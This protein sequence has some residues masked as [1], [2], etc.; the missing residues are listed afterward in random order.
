M[1]KRILHL[2]VRVDRSLEDAIQRETARE[3]KV[4]EADLPGYEIKS[5]EPVGM[6]QIHSD[7]IYY[8]TVEVD[9]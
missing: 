3:L 7:P 5:V 1:A 8:V 2:N 4:N 9:S 6:H